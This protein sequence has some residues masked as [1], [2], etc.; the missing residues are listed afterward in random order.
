[1]IFKGLV[2][3][4]DGNEST[5][6]SIC[7]KHSSV[8]LFPSCFPK[9]EFDYAM[10]IQNE[11]NKLIYLISEDYE[12]IRGAFANIIKVDEFSQNLFR[13]YETVRSEG[14]AQVEYIL[15]NLFFTSSL[16]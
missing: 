4:T 12:F 1:M 7:A 8:S 14:I 2:L 16:K 10:S 15:H 5:P 11:F 3:L 6:K 13:I 9:S